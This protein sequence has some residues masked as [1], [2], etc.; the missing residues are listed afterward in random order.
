MR[1]L[2]VLC[3]VQ[4]LLFLREPAAFFFTLVFPCLLLVIFGAVFGNEPMT[5]W[6]LEVGYID[7]QVPALAA[8]ILGSVGLIGIPSATATAR[9]NR[10]LRRY[11]A[12]PVSPLTLISADVLVNFSMSLLGMTGLVL[13]G[14]VLFGLRF[15]GSWPLVISIF[16]FSAFAFFALG[17]LVA[18]LSPT[19]R[20]AQTVGMAAFFPLMF[21]SGAAMPHQIMP[22]NVLRIAYALPLTHVVKLLQTGWLGEPLA[23]RAA[24][25]LWLGGILVLGTAISVKFFRWE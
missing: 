24:E 16:T 11:R 5:A 25:I 2:I 3:R 9:E 10:V 18:S 1:G 22:E 8:I 15:S 20:V 14:K 12:T 23:G 17:Y 21:L 7:T 19:A 4:A 13:L 6:G